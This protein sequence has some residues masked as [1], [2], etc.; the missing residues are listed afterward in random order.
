MPIKLSKMQKVLRLQMSTVKQ[1]AFYSIKSNSIKSNEPVQ[2]YNRKNEQLASHWKMPIKL[3]KMQK[4]LRL[5]MS[6][7]KQNAF[8][9]IKSNS[10]KS[11]E[12]V[13]FY[14]RKNEQLKR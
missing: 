13:Q 8:Y 3:S 11:N 2:F 10:I 12:P 6:T 5:Q 9:S 7:V 4:V 1:N 14:N